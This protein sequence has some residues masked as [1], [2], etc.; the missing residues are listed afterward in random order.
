M[1]IWWWG[2]GGAGIIQLM[3]TRK[4]KLGKQIESVPRDRKKNDVKEGVYKPW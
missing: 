3:A 2:W 1:D 4:V